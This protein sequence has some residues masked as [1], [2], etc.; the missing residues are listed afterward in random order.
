MRHPLEDLMHFCT[1]ASPLK[2]MVIILLRKTLT[3]EVLKK[4]IGSPF[5]GW[6]FYTERGC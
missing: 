6:Q 2:W 5:F 4:G 3:C 1:L